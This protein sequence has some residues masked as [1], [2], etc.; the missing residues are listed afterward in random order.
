[1][2]R[3][4]S[5]CVEAE[6]AGLNKRLHTGADGGVARSPSVP[7]GGPRWVM[8]SI[9]SVHLSETLLTSS[10]V[11]VCC[12]TWVSGFSQL[13][14]GLEFGMSPKSVSHSKSV[15]WLW[16]YGL[17]PQMPKLEGWAKNKFWNS[18]WVVRIYTCGLTAVLKWRYGNCFCCSFFENQSTF[19]LQCWRVQSPLFEVQVQFICSWRPGRPISLFSCTTF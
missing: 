14:L 2:E 15:S 3:S 12:T 1:M 6:V 16:T 9:R 11:A 10:W 13:Q 7:V 5:Q 4:G 18:R 17:S 19:R 8:A